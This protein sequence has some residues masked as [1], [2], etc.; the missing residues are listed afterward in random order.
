MGN[1]ERNQAAQDQWLD[2]WIAGDLVELKGDDYYHAPIE[3]VLEADGIS[4]IAA[5]IDAMRQGRYTAMHA[6]VVKLL[7]DIETEIRKDAL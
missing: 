5:A 6:L 4:D 7:T 2:D 3:R 1:D